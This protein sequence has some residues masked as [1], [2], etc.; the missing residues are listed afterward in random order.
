MTTAPCKDCPRRQPGCHDRCEDYK[1]YKQAAAA[2]K[3]WL[4]AGRAADGVAI[5]AALQ[6]G[7]ERRRRK[8][9]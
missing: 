8:G 5:K 9:R 7:R 4:N 6:R 2:E 3:E 1:A